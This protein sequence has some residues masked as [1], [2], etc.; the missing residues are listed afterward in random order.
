MKNCVAF[1]CAL[2]LLLLLLLPFR[3]IWLAPLRRDLTF[4]RSK[5]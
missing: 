3:I 1:L 2:E 4:Q 5:H